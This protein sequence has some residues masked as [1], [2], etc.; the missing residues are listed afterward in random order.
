MSA[1]AMIRTFSDQALDGAIR[2]LSFNGEWASRL[3]ELLAEKAYRKASGLSVPS[4]PPT[5]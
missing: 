5:P 3:R 2:Q 4:T 1:A